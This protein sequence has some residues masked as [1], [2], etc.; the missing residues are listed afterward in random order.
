[1]H[2]QCLDAP[3]LISYQNL[4]LKDLKGANYAFTCAN[5]DKD[6]IAKNA[7]LGEII[8]LNCMEC[9]V[10]M[11]LGFKTH[12]LLEVLQKEQPLDKKGIAASKAKKNAA[13]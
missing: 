13:K 5:C 9:F 4:K 7:T 2:L 8:D 10:K 1:M 11:K 12:N 3:A 6:Y